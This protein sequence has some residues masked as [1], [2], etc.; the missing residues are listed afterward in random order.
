MDLAVALEF[1]SARRRGVLVTL[2]G[3]GRPQLSNIFYLVGPDGSVRVS[4]TDD[5]AKTVNLRRDPRAQLYVTRDDFFAY[6]VLDG[7]ASLSP[8]AGAVDDPVVDELVDMYRLASGEHPDWDDFRRTMVADRRLVLTL[9]PSSAYGMV[10][11]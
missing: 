11:R 10:D 9:A 6:A 1:V 4:V 5:R 7:T 2:R 3:D 8:V